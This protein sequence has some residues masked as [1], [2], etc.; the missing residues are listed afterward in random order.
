MILLYL[1]LA[2]IGL[3]CFGFAGGGALVAGLFGYRLNRYRYQYMGLEDRRFFIPRLWRLWK[4]SLYQPVV[5]IGLALFLVS[6]LSL[7]LKPL[8]TSGIF[9]GDRGESEAALRVGSL[10]NRIYAM[11]EWLQNGRLIHSFLIMTLTLLVVNLIWPNIKLFN[12]VPKMRVRIRNAMIFLTTI[13]AF[14]FV[15]AKNINSNRAIVSANLREEVKR[16]EEELNRFNSESAACKI[17]KDSIDEMT[18]EEIRKLAIMARTVAALGAA[19]QVS[20]NMGKEA[21]DKFK[22][23]FSAPESRSRT[24]FDRASMLDEI[25]DWPTLSERRLNASNEAKRAALIK[26]ASRE[27]MLG[28]LDHISVDI[29]KHLG[30]SVD[31]ASRAVIGSFFSAMTE[32]VTE[33]C[34]TVRPSKKIASDTEI[35]EQL[36]R[37]TPSAGTDRVPSAWLDEI[38]DVNDP[39]KLAASLAKRVESIDAD[40]KLKSAAKAA[41]AAEKAADA[42]KAAKAAKNLIKFIL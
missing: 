27:A 23:R 15:S 21:G 14:T 3:I 39:E 20:E 17:V 35:L 10:E 28:S 32:S 36:S 24:P 11:T 12:E 34:S 22:S 33:L 42:A 19:T 18:P 29:G 31:R 4:F 41:R 8:V 26:K 13:S 40:F 9:G 2:A 1:L 25:D 6:L 7:F 5:C 30:G 37:R 16:S 38:G